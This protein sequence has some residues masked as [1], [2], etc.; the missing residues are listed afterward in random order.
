MR[1]SHQNGFEKKTIFNYQLLIPYLFFNDEKSK[2][3]RCSTWSPPPSGTIFDPIYLFGFYRYESAWGMKRHLLVIEN[4]F[5]I[6]L[7]VFHKFL[8]RKTKSDKNLWKIVKFWN[9]TIFHNFLSFLVLSP[10]NLWKTDKHIKNGFSM[11][12]RCL[13]IHKHCHTYKNQR[14]KLD[15]K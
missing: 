2:G 4:P 14:D 3:R 9:F 7:S 15:Q 6:C 8:G 11:T 5:L 1:I 13:F 12:R 10:K